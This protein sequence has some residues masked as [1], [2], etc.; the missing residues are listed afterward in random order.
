MSI[1]FLAICVAAFIFPIVMVA[2][3]IG[4]EESDND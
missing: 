2:Y 3:A 1:W 4:Q